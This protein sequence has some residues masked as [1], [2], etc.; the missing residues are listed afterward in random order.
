MLFYRHGINTRIKALIGS[1]EIGGYDAAVE[2]INTS[3]PKGAPSMSKGTISKRLRDNLE[4]PTTEWRALEEAA[5]RYPVSRFIAARTA[6]DDAG[7]ERSFSHLET[8]KEGH[9]AVMA[10]ALAE[11]TDDPAVV[12]RAIEE[13]QEVLDLAAKDL[14]ALRQRYDALRAAQLTSVPRV[15]S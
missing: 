11:T 4:W 12:M 6:E 8:M 14:P 13:T 1:P 3:R 15:V 2:I 10:Q 9:E 7:D 5:G